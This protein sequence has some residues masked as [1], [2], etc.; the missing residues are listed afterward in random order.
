MQWFLANSG[1]VFSLAGQHLVLAIL[2]MILGLLI[3]IPLAQ[4]ARQNRTLRTVVRLTPRRALNS[5]SDGTIAPTPAWPTMVSMSLKASLKTV[6]LFTG[7]QSRFFRLSIKN[8]LTGLLPEDFDRRARATGDQLAAGPAGAAI[9]RRPF[10]PCCNALSGRKLMQTMDALLCSAPGT[11]ELVQ[12]PIES[13][14]ADQVLV[15][16]RRVGICGTDY[17]IYEGKH[18][19]LAYPRVMG[20]ELAVEIARAAEAIQ[21]SAAERARARRSLR[22]RSQMTLLGH[23][24]IRPLPPDDG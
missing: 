9:G 10:V 20:H 15:R 22:E 6:S 8:R 16:P 19:F 7:A 2:P 23:S 12:R 4:L 24:T 14:A 13:R 18:P 1:Q 3:S 21:R 17:H 11:L 5:F